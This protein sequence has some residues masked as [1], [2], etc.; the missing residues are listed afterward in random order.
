M[1]FITNKIKA[2]LQKSS[3]HFQVALQVMDFKPKH[4]KKMVAAGWAMYRGGK[5]AEKPVFLHLEPTGACN[6][7]CQM[8]PRTE[9]IT[10]ELRHM[11]MELFKKVCDD[12]D[13]VFIAFVGFGEP[14]VNPW[15]LDMVRYAVKKK[16]L[17]R[18]SSNATL[19]TLSRCEEIL[20]SGLHQIWFSIDSPDAAN[21]EKIRV[22]AEF[23]ETIGGIKEFMRLREKFNSKIAVTIN[24]TIIKENVHE[25]AA[26]VQFC[27]DELKATPT[28]ARGYGYDIEAQ[29]QRALQNSPE[30]QA[31]LQKA[32][33]LA[34]E[35]KQEA[36]IQNLQT[37]IYDLKNPLDGKGPCYFPYYTVAVSWDGRVSPC[38]LF[39]DYQMNLG[40][41][42][43]KKFDEVWNGAGYQNFR[44]KLKRSRP[45][46]NI[47]NTC[48][49]NDVSLHNM[50]H[51]IRNIP[52][53]SL[54]TK[55]RYEY[56]DRNPNKA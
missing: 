24:F 19:L 28:F 39:Y 56:I 30:T 17:T 29:K 53:M 26:M 42:K 15:L 4:L 50:M 23:K 22:G 3:Q 1:Q 35:L 8:C 18:I 31:Y 9:S 55:E 25:V 52:G 44:M 37:I 38:C 7:K 40:R 49:L 10:R 41:L 14:F 51:S 46:I 16:I 21:F 12:I 32:L 54:L 47:C 2:R 5:K 45:D 6:L 48:S 20:R 36:V 13:P 34:R 43:D 11:D 27:H 33:D